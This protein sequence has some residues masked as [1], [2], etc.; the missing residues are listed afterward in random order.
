VLKVKHTRI[1][2]P[3]S[4]ASLHKMMSTRRRVHHSPS[5]LGVNKPPKTSLHVSW[6]RSPSLS[7][8]GFGIGTSRTQN[9]AWS[10]NKNY[11]TLLLSVWNDFGHILKLSFV[12]KFEFLPAK[13]NN[14]ILSPRSLKS[15]NMPPEIKKKG[16]RAEHTKLS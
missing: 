4:P 7:A 1:K 2:Y 3:Y 11:W 6:G 14:T 13:L 5:L 15:G 16:V 9:F 10:H 12:I 8:E